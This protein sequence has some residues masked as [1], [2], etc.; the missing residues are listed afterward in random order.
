MSFGCYSVDDKVQDKI[1]DISV[2]KNYT[3]KVKNI[4]P[5][6]D[7]GVAVDGENGWYNHINYRPHFLHWCSAITRN[8]LNKVGGFSEEFANGI[9]YEDNEFLHRVKKHIDIKYV[10]GPIVIHQ[11]HGRTNYSNT[12]LVLKNQMIAKKLMN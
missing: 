11:F 8:D 9:A 3:F 5:F 4:I 12:S 7:N 6:Y 1:N 10:K 2:D